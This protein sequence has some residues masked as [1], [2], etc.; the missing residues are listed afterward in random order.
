MSYPS[1]EAPGQQR[2]QLG[3]WEWPLAGVGPLSHLCDGVNVLQGRL[4]VNVGVF[5]AEFVILQILLLWDKSEPGGSC[6]DTG[7]GEFF[8]QLKEK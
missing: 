6:R 4:K 8:F 1:P 2:V 7:R 5:K 3:K